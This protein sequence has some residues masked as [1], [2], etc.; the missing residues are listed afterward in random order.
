MKVFFAFIVLILLVSACAPQQQVEED[1]QDD[2]D[3]ME[4][5]VDQELEDIREEQENLQEDQEDVDTDD[6]DVEE[7]DKEEQQ[8]DTS[9]K[10]VLLASLGD[11]INKAEEKASK[12][13]SFVY[14]KSGAVSDYAKYYVKGDLVRVDIY[15]KTWLPSEYGDMVFNVVYID[16]AADTATAY[17][18]I[19]LENSPYECDDTP[20][21]MNDV[22]GDDFLI[23]LPYELL[24]TIDKATEKG[25]VKVGSRNALKAE[26]EFKDGDSGMFWLDQFSGLPLQMEK[27]GET[28]YYNSM[29]VGVADDKVTK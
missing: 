24:S 11:I 25:T 15:D 19:N 9:W 4:Q 12:G 17:C 27:A 5:E 16:R 20:D 14:T 29:S 8:L 22:E 21:L 28:F 23:T 18:I 2:L 13:Y 1:L 7:K 3:Q 26:V 10:Q 6:I